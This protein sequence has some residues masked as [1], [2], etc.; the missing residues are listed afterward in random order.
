MTEEGRFIIHAFVAGIVVTYSY[1][2][3]RIFRRVIPHKNILVSLEDI[4]FWIYCAISVFLLMYY[5]GNQTLRWFAVCGALAGMFLYLKL[6]SPIFVNISV[7]LLQKLILVFNRIFQLMINPI[8]RVFR[9]IKKN[10]RFA[11]KKLTLSAKGLRMRIKKRKKK[12]GNN[13]NDR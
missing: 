7:R 13:P 9:R 4:L 10:L 2:L 11:K 3:L 6:V 5:E 12:L 1:D 8:L